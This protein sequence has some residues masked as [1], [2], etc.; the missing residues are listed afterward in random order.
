MEKEIKIGIIG[1]GQPRRV[2][3]QP[4]LDNLPVIKP[5]TKPKNPNI[6]FE[7][8]YFPPEK[9]SPFSKFRR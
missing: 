7:V 6:K 4:F 1:L 5:E 2:D 3:I 8:P 9:K